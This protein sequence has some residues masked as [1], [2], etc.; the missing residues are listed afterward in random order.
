MFKIGIGHSS[1]STALRSRTGSCRGA[2]AAFAGKAKSDQRTGPL[3]PHIGRRR[4]LPRRVLE[5]G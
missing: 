5:S 3:T 1:R 2:L 4:K